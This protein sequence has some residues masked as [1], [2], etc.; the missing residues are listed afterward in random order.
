MTTFFE[1]KLLPPT[2]GILLAAA[3]VISGGQA[4]V[5]ANFRAVYT[6]T[7]GQGSEYLLLAQN[8]GQLPQG[9]NSSSQNQAT[10]SRESLPARIPEPSTVVGLGLVAGSLALTRRRVR[11]K[12]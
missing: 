8:S 7:S 12:N 2:A 3:A 11:V 4:A 9:T 1:R 5:A 6:A 10:P